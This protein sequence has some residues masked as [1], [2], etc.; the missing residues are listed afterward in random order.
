M[1]KSSKMNSDEEAPFRDDTMDTKEHRFEPDQNHGNNEVVYKAHGSD[2]KEVVFSCGKMD[3]SHETVLTS[4][5]TVDKDATSRW[6]LYFATCVI[7]INCFVLVNIISH[8]LL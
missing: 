7:V 2:G 6:N 1:S 8:I 3:A 5:E 4:G